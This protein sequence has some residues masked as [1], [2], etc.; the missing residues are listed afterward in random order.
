MRLRSGEDSS[1][2][3]QERERKGCEEGIG[4]AWWSIRVESPKDSCA[5]PRFSKALGEWQSGVEDDVG[6]GGREGEEGKK[7]KKDETERRGRE[8]Q[9]KLSVRED[10]E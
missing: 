2:E 5:G 9:M 7:G 6:A 10:V 8:K 3:E 1:L 4:D